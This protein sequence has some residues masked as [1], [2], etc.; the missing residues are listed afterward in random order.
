MVGDNG[1][2]SQIDN[3]KD[4]PATA[5]QNRAGLH[6]IAPHDGDPNLTNSR[7]LV[8]RRRIYERHLPGDAYISA[9][10]ERLQHGYFSSSIVSQADIDFVDFLGVNFVFHPSDS[11]SHRFKAATITATI[12]HHPQDTVDNNYFT[13]NNPRFLMFAPH[14]I[15]GAVSP[16]T[17]Q[18]NFNLASSFGIANAPV[19]AL[20]SPSGGLKAQYKLYEMMKIQG[21]LRTL[22][23]HEDPEYNIND[24]KIVWSLTEN[25]LQRSGLPREFTFVMLIQKPRWD[26]RLKFSLEIEPVID[27][28]FGNY[29]NWWLD[30]RR[31][32][33]LTKRLINFR[34]QVG[35]KFEPSQSSRGFNFATLASSLDDYV[36]SPEG[37]VDDPTASG[38][39]KRMSGN[40]GSQAAMPPGSASRYIN[41]S[42]PL[43]GKNFGSL[44]LTAER[45][46]Y[47]GQVLALSNPS[48]S[49][50]NV[51]VF[52]EN[53]HS[54][55][56]A[57]HAERRHQEPAA[58]DIKER[59]IRRSLS[60]EELKQRST[61]QRRDGEQKS[62]HKMASRPFPYAGYSED[63][64]KR[65][66][67]LFNGK[68]VVDAKK[69]RLV[70]EHAYYPTYFFPKSE[71]HL[72]YLKDEK[73]G[74]TDAE[75]EYNLVVHDR[76]AENAVTVFV[77]GPSQNFVKVV[78]SKVDAW[79]EEDERIYV[80][81]KDPYKVF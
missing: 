11:K 17:L 67:V 52:L 5:S 8:N 30:F 53:R 77:A 81:P 71:V 80:H 24:G 55:P 65:V 56:S 69:P 27:A 20:L 21:S 7:L 62:S 31:Y 10:V 34:H 18:W 23:I 13:R 38:M 22:D 54:P 40:P 49:M 32:Q 36:I 19:T 57:L 28:W 44:P 51:R 47:M 76:V 74:A 41:P 58:P 78:F 26:S 64:D 29:P 46:R 6:P 25:A 63:V 35:Q 43:I 50:L 42:A 66:R 2:K 12:E 4:T 3:T 72:E 73:S 33:P 9:H 1:T 61:S 79:F 70:W 48:N 45:I 39:G 60:Q 59:A 68:F 16:E 14:L 75:K 15:Y 37:V